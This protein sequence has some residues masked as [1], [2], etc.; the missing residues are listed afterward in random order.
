MRPAVPGAEIAK[1]V[2][3]RLAP[4]AVPA[5]SACFAV[6]KR[7]ARNRPSAV[8]IGDWLAVEIDCFVE[9][10]AVEIGAN[11]PPEWEG[12]FEQPAAKR[13]CFNRG[14]VHVRVLVG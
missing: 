8:R 14:N 4:R 2:L 10:A 11:L 6:R 3:R 5:K 12:A 13:A 9:A 1:R 7:L